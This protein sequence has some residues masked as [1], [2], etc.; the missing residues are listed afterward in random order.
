MQI[1]VNEV[2]DNEMNV[3]VAL[4]FS[5]HL[6]LDEIYFHFAQILKR[7]GMTN[8]EYL[9]ENDFDFHRYISVKE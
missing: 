6:Q 4:D 8:R 3:F 5:L 9:G 7:L 1:T 2:L